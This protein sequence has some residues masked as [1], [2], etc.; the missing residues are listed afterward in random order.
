MNIINIPLSQIQFFLLIFLRIT[1]IMMVV[2]VFE[3]RNIPVIFKVGLSFAVSII[4]FPLI[5]FD[6]FPV[7][8]GL[9]PFALG[10]AGEIMLGVI[11]GLSVKLLFSGIQLAGQIAGIQMGL[12]I[13]RVLDPNMGTQVSNIGQ[14]FNL[15]ALLMF[16]SINAHHFFLRAIADS[17][18]MVP[19]LSFQFGNSLI[20]YL[21]ILTGNM[22]IIAVKAGAPIMVALLLTSVAF[23]LVAR[24]VPQMNIMIVAMP[25]KIAVGL[26]FL[27]ITLPYLTSYFIQIFNNMGRDIYI[28]LNAM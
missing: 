13:S 18:N 21:I 10:V 19:P 9:L 15:V 20:E 6:S 22:F 16:L 24:T 5:K 25:L 14:I 27:G 2:P 3:N 7:F 28:L 11:I 4:L 8:T 23:G 26:L 1:S 12:G 17:F